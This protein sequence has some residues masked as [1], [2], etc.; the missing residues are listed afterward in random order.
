MERTEEKAQK[1]SHFRFASL[2]LS[3]IFF[4]IFFPYAQSEFLKLLCLEINTWK[5]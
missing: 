3:Q 4:A 5:Q 2:Y 1:A